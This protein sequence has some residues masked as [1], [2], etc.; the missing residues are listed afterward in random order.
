MKPSDCS[1][2]AMRILRAI[3]NDSTEDFMVRI[4]EQMVLTK[5][6][7]AFCLK[8]SEV[9]EPMSANNEVMTSYD[10]VVT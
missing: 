6:V 3:E 9:F 10:E 4:H 5:K 2:S 7:P 8:V 1:C